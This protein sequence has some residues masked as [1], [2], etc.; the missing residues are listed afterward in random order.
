ME[1]AARFDLTGKQKFPAASRLCLGYNCCM[2]INF[3]WNIIAAGAGVIAAVA[4]V[5]GVFMQFAFRWLD[6]RVVI[7]L[8][9]KWE[10]NGGYVMLNSGEEVYRYSIRCNFGI[11]NSGNKAVQ[12]SA[13]EYWAADEWKSCNVSL[14]SAIIQPGMA[15][16]FDTGIP[17]T[18]LFSEQ[19]DETL[20]KRK[21]FRVKTSCGKEFYTAGGN[22][23]VNILRE[24]KTKSGAG[25]AD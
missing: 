2:N 6:Q 12:I 5:S 13:I 3:D 7:K 15:D 21:I 1:V 25:K 18:K 24:W 20:R 16:G 22:E 17:D 11:Y 23:F 4:A 19:S 14:R 9:L 8:K 10:L